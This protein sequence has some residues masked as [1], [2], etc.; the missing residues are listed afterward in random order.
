MVFARSQ[1]ARAQGRGARGS[2]LTEVS[3]AEKS[4][5]QTPQVLTITR[6]R[7]VRISHI[8]LKD[9]SFR[10]QII[11]ELR[12]KGGANDPKLSALGE[13][14]EKFPP[15]V[16][17]QLP[18]P[19]AKWFA[20]QISIKNFVEEQAPL[21]DNVHVQGDDVVISRRYQGVFFEV[22]EMDDFPFDRQELS[23]YLAVN[24]RPAGVTP[25]LLEVADDAEIDISKSGFRSCTQEYD[26]DNRLTSEAIPV[27][28]P[29]DLYP[30]VKICARIYRDPTYIIF[31]LMVP[32]VLF[33]FLQL[34]QFCVPTGDQEV[35]LAVTLTV[36]LTAN[37]YKT[38]TMDMTPRVSYLTFIDRYMHFVSYIMI[39]TVAEGAIV[40]Q[41]TYLT[42]RRYGLLDGPSPLFFFDLTTTNE[43][44]SAATAS[45]DDWPTSY[46]AWVD[47]SCLLVEVAAITLLHVWFCWKVVRLY[48][49]RRLID[50]SVCKVHGLRKG[51]WR[52]RILANRGDSSTNPLRKS[53]INRLSRLSPK[54]RRHAESLQTT[55]KAASDRRSAS[56]L[57][58]AGPTSDVPSGIT[59]QPVRK[60]VTAVDEADEVSVPHGRIAADA[61]ANDASYPWTP[62][63][64][65]TEG[66][67]KEGATKEV[68]TKEGATEG[69]TKE[70]A[71][72]AAKVPPSDMNRLSS[73]GVMMPP[74]AEG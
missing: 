27:A 1:K 31:N 39:I 36:L 16:E 68:A 46:P 30:T 9:Q 62:A 49:V 8:D 58:A 2:L 22:F 35:R 66:A 20:G 61:P 72:T 55:A 73:G 24:C 34:L 5:K 43:N 56:V 37:A 54:R 59:T 48:S 53:V 60:R 52:A 67:T 10:A 7:F 15:R 4:F 11:V 21:D 57:P 33:L 38:V 32:M 44:A 69:A 51:T 13:G 3:K 47:F 25:C 26:L 6:F 63:A 70:G 71:T 45:V 40:G 17:G 18:R 28:P 65:T 29:D 19:S 64:A 14:S 50:T 42:N 12:F 74:P 23:I 41:I